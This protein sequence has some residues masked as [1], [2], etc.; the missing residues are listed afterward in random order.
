[1]TSEPDFWKEM[2]KAWMHVIIEGIMKEYNSKMELARIFVDNY[3]QI[4]TNFVS[5]DQEE[6]LTIVNMTVQFFTVKSIAHYLLEATDVFSKLVD[7]FATRIVD[8]IKELQPEDLPKE[9]FQSGMDI[10][11]SILMVEEKAEYSRFE[12][13]MTDLMYLLRVPFESKNFTDP[14]RRNFAKGTESFIHLISYLQYADPHKRQTGRHVEYESGEWE[15]I[16]KI[17]ASLASISHMIHKWCS[18]DK[19]LLVTVTNQIVKAIFDDQGPFKPFNC[20]LGNRKASYQITKKDVLKDRVS[21]NLPYQ[22]FLSGLLPLFSGFT[23]EFGETLPARLASFG[24][25]YHIADPAITAVATIASITAGMWRLNG[26]PAAGQAY[27]YHN[28]HLCP[29][30]KRHDLILLQSCCC[31]IDDPGR[32][33]M[34]LLD[35]FGLIAFVNKEKDD[36][37]EDEDTVHK[38]VSMVETYLQVILAIVLERHVHNIGKISERD[39]LKHRI[40]QLICSEVMSHS[41]V[42]QALEVIEEEV[43]VV[44][45]VLKNVADLK[46]SSKDPNKKVYE[47][48][49]RIPVSVQSVLLLLQ[50]GDRIQGLGQTVGVKEEKKGETSLSSSRV[51]RTYT[52]L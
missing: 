24:D 8:H 2:R 37:Q 10:S 40:V 47:V 23:E 7:M 9:E 3:V 18:R 51:T 49:K 50:S 4:M 41:K 19:G 16:G 12:S 46:G 27:L 38:K 30:L 34:A 39:E 22:R 32:I 35:R 33:T 52:N 20:Q 45:E 15:Y 13:I 44:D 25:V 42:V 21:V 48:K 29:S 1:M 6:D 14:L 11:L 43:P 28:F 36:L 17:S 31:T 5:D 26:T